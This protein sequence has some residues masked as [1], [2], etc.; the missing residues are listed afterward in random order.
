MR[1]CAVGS[2]LTVRAGVR[3][4]SRQTKSLDGLQTLPQRSLLQSTVRLTSSY[5][6]TF[7]GE[8]GN[9][10]RNTIA[11]L[12]WLGCCAEQIHHRHVRRRQHYQDT[13]IPAHRYFG[14]GRC[15]RSVRDCCPRTSDNMLWPAAIE[16]GI[17]T[18]YMIISP[19]LTDRQNP[20]CWGQ[21]QDG[22]RRGGNISWNGRHQQDLVPG[23]SV[24]HDSRRGHCLRAMRKRAHC[25][26]TYN[27]GNSLRKFADR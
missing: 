20:K 12:V 10:R 9:V 16:D 21:L 27:L 23:A 3:I 6:R 1:G 19:L 15:L 26:T 4:R 18:H 8:A 13:C 17:L 2:V 25:C 11:K 22:A 24:S 14:I 7:A 5:M